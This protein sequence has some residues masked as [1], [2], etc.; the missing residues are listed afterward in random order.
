MGQEPQT[1]PFVNAITREVR[2]SVL[3]AAG[4]TPTGA[5]CKRRS[6]CDRQPRLCNRVQR[7]QELGLGGLR[8][9]K[10]FPVLRH[11]AS[12]ALAMKSA[13]PS[14]LFTRSMSPSATASAFCSRRRLRV[15][16]DEAG[17]GERRR[18]LTRR[19]TGGA[20]GRGSAAPKADP[21]DPPQTP[22]GWRDVRARRARVASEAPTNQGQSGGLA[23]GGTFISDRIE[24]ISD[25]RSISQPISAS[26][27]ASMK[28][29]WC[30][31]PRRL[32]QKAAARR[33]EL[34][35]RRPQGL[36]DEG[37]DGVEKLQRLVQRPG[38]GMARVS[39][40]AASSS[41]FRIGLASSRCQS[42]KVFQMKR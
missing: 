12:G 41:P 26:A 37:R 21:L 28:A 29:G 4:T 35:G 23:A 7:G 38:G 16:V 17:D 20:A 15:H 24:R 11:H 6:P 27:S 42:Q 5:V 2:R 18:S 32:H 19:K 22:A 10:L 34:G 9:R 39:A 8:L 30:C 14:F 31:G 33:P 36:G 25:T 13:L 3:R 40:L 1:G